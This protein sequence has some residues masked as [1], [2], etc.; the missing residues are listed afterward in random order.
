MLRAS[1]LSTWSG[2]ELTLPAG[3]LCP[4]LHPAALLSSEVLPSSKVTLFIL[5]LI[6]I[7]QPSLAVSPFYHFAQYPA[8]PATY[9]AGPRAQ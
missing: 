2:L 8:E 7:A 9:F 4:A 3:A 6:C 1:S 5:E